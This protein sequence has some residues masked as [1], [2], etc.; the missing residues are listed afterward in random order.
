[1]KAGNREFTKAAESIRDILDKNQL[2]EV[3]YFMDYFIDSFSLTLD[4][5]E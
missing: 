3:K 1:M 4:E 2:P 5:Q